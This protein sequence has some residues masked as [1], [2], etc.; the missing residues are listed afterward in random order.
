MSKA[1]PCTPS[2]SSPKAQARIL[3]WSSMWRSNGRA[4]RDDWTVADLDAA[5]ALLAGM[6]SVDEDHI[7]ILGHCWGGRVKVAFADGGTPPSIW[8]SASPAP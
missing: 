2:C 4:F 5:F 7:G 1:R 3:A 6:D 8:L